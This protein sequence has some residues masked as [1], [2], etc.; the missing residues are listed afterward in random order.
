MSIKL[1]Q[2][3]VFKAI[4]DPIRREIIHHVTTAP[5]ALTINDIAGQFGVSRQA[6]TRHINILDDAGL[7]R[8]EWEGRERRCSA[9]LQGLKVVADWVSTYQAFWKD[10]LMRL[11]RHLNHAAEESGSP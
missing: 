11:E 8:S 2:D 10:K 7:I 3:T 1:E 6:V 5:A 4:A 9:D